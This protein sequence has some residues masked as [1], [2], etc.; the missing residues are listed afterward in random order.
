MLPKLELYAIGALLLLAVA[1]ALYFKGHHDGVERT[2][3]KVAAA[4]A[5]QAE[6]SR[7]HEQAERDKLLSVSQSYEQQISQ[8]KVDA[9]SRPARIVRLCD[10]TTTATVSSSTTATG[11]SQSSA[12]VESSGTAGRDIGRPLYDYADDFKACAVQVNSLLDAWP[13]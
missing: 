6:E 4:A 1:A 7:Q 3:E 11:E 10:A 2:E 13:K 12:T 8:I 9:A 5:K